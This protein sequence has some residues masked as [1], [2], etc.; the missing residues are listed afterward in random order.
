MPRVNDACPRYK[1]KSVQKLDDN[2]FL[3]VATLKNGKMMKSNKNMI[4]LRHNK[5]ELTLINPVRLDDEG[6]ATL[7]KL[8]TI[9]RLIRLAPRQGVEHDKYYLSRFPTVRR[10][11]PSRGT[12]DELPVHRIL[13]EDDDAILPACHVF[14]FQ[15]TALPECALVILQDYV[16][17][18]LVTAEALQAHRDNPHINLA[19]RTQLAARGLLVR[20]VVIPPCWLKQM[21][22]SAKKDKNGIRNDM[23]SLLRLDFERLVGCTGVMIHQRAKEKVVVAVEQS[24]PLW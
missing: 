19:A 4:I 15:G 22:S 2:A 12:D 8:G 20:D 13:T 5:R 11:A 14:S 7:Q 21:Q 24:L 23:E 3:V 9:Q 18:L 17:N 16:G 10:W 1:A 6:E